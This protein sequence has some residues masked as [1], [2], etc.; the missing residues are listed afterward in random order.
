[1]DNKL[2]FEKV[3]EKLRKYSGKKDVFLREKGNHAIKDALKIALEMGRKRV[4][5]QDQGGWIT[6][7]QF[8]LKLG[9]ELVEIET[10]YGLFDEVDLND[11]S[12]LL[13]NAMPSYHAFLDT[14]KLYELC[15]KK[16]ILMITD[17][18]GSIGEEV[19][20]DIIIGSFGKWKPVNLE[21]GGFIAV[22]SEVVKV[23]SS[24]DSEAVDSEAVDSFDSNKIEELNEKL[25]VLEE[26]RKMLFDVHDKIVGD[27][28]YDIV[29][30]DMKGFNVL[31]RTPENS[32]KL[33]V[34]QYCKDNNFE[35]VEC[36]KYIKM[37]DKGIC[38][39][40]KRL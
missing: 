29:H 1:M 35:F 40:V 22:D 6:Y 27:L 17:I 38:I 8:P 37:L 2:V 21:Y 26:R 32:Q 23:V 7:K 33:K 39:E 15:K 25:N 12:V 20:G 19:Y 28:K 34:E 36:P 16:G 4:F 30:K 14:K 31:I 18:S 11:D 10:D 13:V 9:M 24:E 3:H 5:I